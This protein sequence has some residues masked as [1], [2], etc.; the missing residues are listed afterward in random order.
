MSDTTLPL[1]RLAAAEEA[2]RRTRARGYWRTVGRRLRRDH[3]TLFF[4][5]VIAIIVLKPKGLFAL[6]GR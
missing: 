2:P 3:V 6:K 5:A 1:P 4:V